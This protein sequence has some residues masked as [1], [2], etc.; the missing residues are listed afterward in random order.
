MIAVPAIAYIYAIC[1]GMDLRLEELAAKATNTKTDRA[2]RI[3]LNNGI[4]VNRRE[5]LAA[6]DQLSREHTR[7]ATFK[8]V[9]EDLEEDQK[10]KQEEEK[11]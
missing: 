1:H 2:G 5:L 7:L 6:L 4:W 8:E 9:F 3:N 11:E 10:R